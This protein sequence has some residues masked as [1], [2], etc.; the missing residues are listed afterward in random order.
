MNVQEQVVPEVDP[1]LRQQIED[2][3]FTANKYN[4][5]ACHQESDA[6]IPGT[7]PVSVL[8]A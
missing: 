1:A 7:N 8:Y 5:F 6:P 4:F 2:M 3:G